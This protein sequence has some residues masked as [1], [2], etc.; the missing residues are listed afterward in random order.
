MAEKM[1]REPERSRTGGRGVSMIDGVVGWLGGQGLPIVPR[2]PTLNW[3]NR[4]NGA[5]QVTMLGVTRRMTI[6]SDGLEGMSF[7]DM[8]RQSLVAGKYC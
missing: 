4:A 7:D 5:E 3:P 2:P 1:A 6:T 8:L